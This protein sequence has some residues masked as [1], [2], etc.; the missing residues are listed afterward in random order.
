MDVMIEY[1]LVI[2]LLSGTGKAVSV[3]K[4]FDKLSCDQAA[5]TV[6][7]EAIKKTSYADATAFCIRVE[8]S[9]YNPNM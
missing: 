8:N 1:A 9:Q 3:T 5:F 6:Q 7:A 4:G 2:M